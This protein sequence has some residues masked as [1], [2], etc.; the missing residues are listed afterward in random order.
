MM[1]NVTSR[2]W[3]LTVCVLC[4]AFTVTLTGCEPLK[5]KFVRQKKKD[6]QTDD[7]FIPVLEPEVYEVKEVGPFEDYSQQYLLFNVWISDFG[8][9]FQTMDNDKRLIS[10][11]EAALKSINAMQKLSTGTVADA[12]AKITKQVEYLRGEYDRPAAF[13]NTSRMSSEVRSIERSLRRE[14]KPE[15]VKDQLVTP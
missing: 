9:N 14:L 8:D 6:K 13:R 12:I 10:D 1:N 2:R 15:L 11:L 7:K 4:L 5:K 3:L